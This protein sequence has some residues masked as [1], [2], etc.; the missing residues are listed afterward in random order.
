MITE[1]D[2]AENNSDKFQ[3]LQSNI[4]RRGE[5][6][7]QKRKTCGN[8][9]FFGNQFSTLPLMERVKKWDVDTSKSFIVFTGGSP[10]VGTFLVNWAEHDIYCG[11]GMTMVA[12]LM[13]PLRVGQIKGLMGGTGGAAQYESLLNRKGEATALQDAQ[14]LG[15]LLIIVLVILGNVSFVL[16]R[17]SE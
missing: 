8:T 7:W 14:S 17:K 9:D 11:S 6:I 12:G 5:N 13:S 4:S 10:G 3:V 1:T 15:H 2:L 16:K